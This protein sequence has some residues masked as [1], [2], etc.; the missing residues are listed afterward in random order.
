MDIIDRLEPEDA[1]AV[2]GCVGELGQTDAYDAADHRSRVLG[3]A[4]SFA[5]DQLAGSRVPADVRE[6][7]LADAVSNWEREVESSVLDADMAAGDRGEALEVAGRLS[8]LVGEWE[9]VRGVATGGVADDLD[10]AMDEVTD[11]IDHARRTLA[12]LVRPLA[13]EAVPEGADGP[14]ITE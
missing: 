3:L 12:P 14:D 7:G 13:D 1:D 2:R 4:Q 5:F 9:L 11:D 10:A 8:R 6:D